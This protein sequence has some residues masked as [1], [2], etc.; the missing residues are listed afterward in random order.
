MI[1]K[2]YPQTGKA[3]QN[4]LSKIEFG[5]FMLMEKYVQLVLIE[6]IYQSQKFDK[7]VPFKDAEASSLNI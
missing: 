4:I 3:G 2:K 1:P 5:E 6:C 7:V